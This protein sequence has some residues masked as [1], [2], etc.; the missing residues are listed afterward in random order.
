MRS[1]MA[2]G[3]SSSTREVEAG[4]STMQAYPWLYSQEPEAHLLQDVM[5][6]PVRT[7]LIC[8]HKPVSVFCGHT[9]RA[10]GTDCFLALISSLFDTSIHLAVTCPVFS[11]TLALKKLV[12]GR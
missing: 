11:R 10:V 3:C 4:W 12:M 6:H 1:G 8:E 2:H 5:Y 7:I 9:G